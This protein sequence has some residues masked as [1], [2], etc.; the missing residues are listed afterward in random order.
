MLSN[1]LKLVQS[2]ILKVDEERW[3]LQQQISHKNYISPWPKFIQHYRCSLI[4]TIIFNLP[5]SPFS[6]ANQ[7]KKKKTSNE[8][9]C[10]DCPYEF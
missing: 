4:T 10:S 9:V 7:K 8:Q 1:C 6:L 3:G 5:S 2:E